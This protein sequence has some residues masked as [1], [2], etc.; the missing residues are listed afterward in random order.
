MH[1][2]EKGVKVAL[3]WCEFTRHGPCAGD[4]G[5]VAAVLCASIDQYKVVGV[6]LHVVGHVVDGVGVD[7]TSNDRNV[8]GTV[9]AVLLEP[10]VEER[11]EVLL[12]RERLAH[13][14]CDGAT[15]VL[16]CSAHVLNLCVALDN[17]KFI[18]ERS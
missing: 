1:V 12:G 13:S 6:Q 17:S 11:I 10:V 15:G 14:V 2:Q 18:E 5:D 16:P 9:A 8:R 3:G 7:A 4:V